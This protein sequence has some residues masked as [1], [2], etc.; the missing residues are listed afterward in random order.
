LKNLVRAAVA[1][2]L[3]GENKPKSTPKPKRAGKA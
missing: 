2:N 3:K 1:L